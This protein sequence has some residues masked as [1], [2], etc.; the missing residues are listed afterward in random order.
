M[1]MVLFFYTSGGYKVV[2][3]IPKSICPK[4]NTTVQL[5]FKLAYYDI[6]VEHVSNYATGTP[7]THWKIVVYLKYYSL[8]S[9]SL[10]PDF[11][12]SLYKASRTISSTP[13]II[14]ITFT[15]KL[16]NIFYSDVIVVSAAAILPRIFIFSQTVF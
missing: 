7:L 5:E 12:Q 16:C 15:F 9:H 11:S 1:V 4:M 8:H 14:S 3:T 13:M 6:A 10:F 2:H